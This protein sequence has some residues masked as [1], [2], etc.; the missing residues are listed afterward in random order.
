MMLADRLDA[1]RDQEQ[2]IDNAVR[3]LFEQLRGLEDRAV[4]TRGDLGAAFGVEQLD[5]QQLGEL[6]ARHD[7]LLA[8]A[9]K[10]VVGALA[11]IHDALDSKQRAGRVVPRSAL[12]REAG[13]D[14]TTVGECTVDVHVSKLRKKLGDAD[15]IKTVRG[16]GYV[17]GRGA[18]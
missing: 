13:R 11:K 18:T 1:S 2:A 14:D 10:A 4:D 6:F 16:V 9:R 8:E 15:K 3:E 12:L 7:E 17:L 5:E